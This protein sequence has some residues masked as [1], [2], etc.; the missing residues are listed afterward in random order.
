MTYLDLILIGIVIMFLPLI[1][2]VFSPILSFIG[3]FI[4]GFGLAGIFLGYI[5][6]NNGQT[7]IEWMTGLINPAKKSPPKKVEF[8]RIQP[9]RNVRAKKPEEEKINVIP[10]EILYPISPLPKLSHEELSKRGFLYPPTE[11]TTTYSVFFE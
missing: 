5:V 11:L 6:S 8:R 4:I 3:L 2:S 9:M 7:F 1:V 10:Q